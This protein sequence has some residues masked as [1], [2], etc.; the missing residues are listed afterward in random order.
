MP[1]NNPQHK[2]KKK[3]LKNRMNSKNLYWIGWIFSYT[4]QPD[5]YIKVRD[6]MDDDKKV[7]DTACVDDDL[8]FAAMS[9]PDDDEDD[10]DFSDT[11]FDSDDDVGF[12]D[13][14]DEG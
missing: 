4:N 6:L 11:G 9:T 8:D 5:N 3:I 1:H 10:L 14:D 12:D 7:V 2:Q 13:D